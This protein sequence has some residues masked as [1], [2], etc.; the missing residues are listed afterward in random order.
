MPSSARTHPG[1]PLQLAVVEW[2]PAAATC[3]DHHPGGDQLMSDMSGRLCRSSEFDNR[4]DLAPDTLYG[5]ELRG[6]LWHR[7]QRTGWTP[8]ALYRGAAG[9]VTGYATSASTLDN[10]RKGRS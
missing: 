1:P 5:I 9:H 7:V 6:P 10:H 2:D 8:L 4:V 3:Q